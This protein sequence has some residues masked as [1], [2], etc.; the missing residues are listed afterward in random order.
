MV[1]SQV[2]SIELAGYV[3]TMHRLSTSILLFTKTT[4]PVASNHIWERC[5]FEHHATMNIDEYPYC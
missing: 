4:T 3:V 2:D 1:A 5:I